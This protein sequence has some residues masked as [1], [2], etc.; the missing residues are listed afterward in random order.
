MRD[1]RAGPPKPRRL[2][3]SRSGPAAPRS[4]HWTAR[5]WSRSRRSCRR[6]ARRHR[7]RCRRSRASARSPSRASACSSACGRRGSASHKTPIFQGRA[8]PRHCG[9]KECIER[10]AGGA[11]GREH[12]LDLGRD[13]V[14]IRRPEQAAA[15][16]DLGGVD[17][18][19]AGNDRAV[20]NA[21]HERRIVGAPIGVDQQARKGRQHG[22]RVRAGSRDAASARPRRYRRRYGAPEFRAADRA[23][24]SRAE[25][26]CEAWSQMTR[27]PASSAPSICST[28][29]KAS[30]ALAISSARRGSIGPPCRWVAARI[31]TARAAAPAVIASEAKSIQ[32]SGEHAARSLGRGPSCK[33]CG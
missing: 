5:G 13:R 31:W 17:S 27:T 28:G 4:A 6:R 21:H 26:R 25:R 32:P 3:A 11:S 8:T 12:L 15:A 10:I 29:L 24:H 30:C 19:V 2:P 9:V 33:P 16:F 1:G 18:R 22:R 23:R 14:A 7:V 20:G